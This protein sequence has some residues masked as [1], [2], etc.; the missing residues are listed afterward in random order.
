MVVAFGILARISKCKE[1]RDICVQNKYV[2]IFVGRLAQLKDAE[3]HLK[4]IR[5]VGSGQY[6]SLLIS[7]VAEQQLVVL[8]II[9][10]LCFDQSDCV[11]LV[12]QGVATAIVESTAAGFDVAIKTICLQIFKALSFTS[13]KTHATLVQNG[14][15]KVVAQ[16]LRDGVGDAV[17]LALCVLS[18]LAFV[19]SNIKPIIDCGC[20][21]SLT[22]VLRRGSARERLKAID[23]FRNLTAGEY[24]SRLIVPATKALGQQIG[25]ADLPYEHRIRSLVA[26]RSLARFD[27]SLKP[28]LEASILDL[29]VSLL[30]GPDL[31]LSTQA[32]G[33]LVNVLG[34]TAIAPSD[35][36]DTFSDSECEDEI[37]ASTTFGKS[38]SAF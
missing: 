3:R 38:S 19:A 31:R 15:L 26:M 5:A 17:H 1:F 35:A 8:T 29:A 33:L 13:G 18:N 6:L 22:N 12:E 10:N 4:T 25:D 9:H 36:Q 21:P 27:Q 34:N 24:D 37:R 14:V 2:R 11:T 30:Q 20:L 16:S 32:L 23:V 28:F 7:E